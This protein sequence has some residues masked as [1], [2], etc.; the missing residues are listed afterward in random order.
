M[1][2]PRGRQKGG[3]V[4]PTG[5]EGKNTS[6]V[7]LRATTLPMGREVGGLECQGCQAWG[8]GGKGSQENMVT[9]ATLWGNPW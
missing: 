9:R 2:T 1:Q 5:E 4:T 3:S 8:I 6:V 7:K